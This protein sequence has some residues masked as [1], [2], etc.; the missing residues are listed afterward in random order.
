[1]SD[2]GVLNMILMVVLLAAAIGCFLSVVMAW[3]SGVP[4]TYG[5]L[6]WFGAASD[7]VP[8]AA[9]PHIR[10]AWRFFGIAAASQITMAALYHLAGQT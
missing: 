1:M 7:K 5:G 3:R 2:L 9:R 6:G 4:I 8:D 10:R